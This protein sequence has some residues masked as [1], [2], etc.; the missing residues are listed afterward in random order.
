LAGF[1]W[2]VL[3]GLVLIEMVLIELVLI[4]VRFDCL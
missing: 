4:G 2:L 3:I 1:D